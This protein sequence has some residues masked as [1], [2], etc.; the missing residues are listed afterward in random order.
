MNQ[1]EERPCPQFHEQSKG[2]KSSS[3]IE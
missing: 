1:N 2:L 3:F